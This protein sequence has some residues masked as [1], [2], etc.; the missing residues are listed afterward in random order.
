MPGTRADPLFDH[1][2]SYNDEGA[3]GCPRWDRGKYR[4]EEDRDEEHQACHDGRDTRLATLWSEDISFTKGGR[5]G[6][7]EQYAPAIPVAD[8]M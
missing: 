1:Q 8:S 3:A 5:R 6:H 2:R 7:P 4:G